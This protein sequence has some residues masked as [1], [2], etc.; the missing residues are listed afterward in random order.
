MTGEANKDFEAE[1]ALQN[2]FI[3]DLCL[4]EFANPTGTIVRILFG[5][6]NHRENV[7]LT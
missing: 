7:D 2:V 5:A 4:T 1:N 6:A 3:I